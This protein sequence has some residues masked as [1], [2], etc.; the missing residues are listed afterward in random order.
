MCVNVQEGLSSGFLPSY[1]YRRQSSFPLLGVAHRSSVNK[2]LIEEKP[3]NILH[4]LSK[5]VKK[6]LLQNVRLVNLLS[7]DAQV[8]LISSGNF[9]DK[10]F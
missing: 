1:N 4:Q 3:L 6:G 5:H 10:Q 8:M 9:T 7:S 2:F